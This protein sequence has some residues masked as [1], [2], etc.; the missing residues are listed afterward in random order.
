ME[1]YLKSYQ[2]VMHTVGPVFV[3]SGREIKKKEYLFL[4]GRKIVGIPD[5]QRLYAELQ[6]R[7]KETVFEEYLLGNGNMDLTEWLGKQKIKPEELKPFLKYTLDCNGAILEKKSNVMECIKDAYGN[8]YVP[9][10]S[11]KGMFRTILLGADII[12]N[13]G[14]YQQEK[15]NMFREADN[16]G[17]RNSYLKR[18][19]DEIEAKA[20]RGLNRPE[21]NKKDAVN[22]LLQGFIVSDSEPLSTENLTLCQKIDVHTDGTEKKLP[23]LRECIKPGTEVRFILTIDT[24][25]CKLSGKLLMAAVKLFTENYYD[26]FSGAFSGM[27][28]PKQNEV[29]CGGGCGFLSKTIVYPMYGKQEGI[30][31]AQS[32]FKNT[33][34]GKMQAQHKHHNDKKYG[35]S[36]HTIK[37]TRYQGKLLQMGVCRIKKIVML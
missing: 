22:D 30:E 11:L 31:F 24:N 28:M 7:K 21:T 15:R 5:I 18:N 26:C 27:G 29:F 9:G 14:K 34:S 32:V 16:K 12:Q 17:A 6:K 8:P 37:C 13:P 2:V 3:G 19:I 35:A 25:I 1:K 4:N 33:I 10:S 20:Y 23:L 36:P